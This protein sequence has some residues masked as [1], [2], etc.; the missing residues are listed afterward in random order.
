MGNYQKAIES[1]A[2]H[3]FLLVLVCASHGQTQMTSRPPASEMPSRPPISEMPSRPPISEMPSRPPISEMPSRPP[4]SAMPGKFPNSGPPGTTA[5]RCTQRE[6]TSLA[7]LMDEY[8]TNWNFS[9]YLNPILNILS[10]R[11]PCVTRRY[12]SVILDY[13]DANET[14]TTDKLLFLQSVNR[15]WDNT[16]YEHAIQ[17]N[18]SLLYGLKRALKISPEESVIMVVTTGSMV[19]YNNSQLLSE[20]YTLLRNKRSQVYFLWV[21][22]YC[23]LS[24]NQQDIARNISDL[25][26]GD[27]IK[28][29]DS[30]NTGQLMRTLELLLAKPLNSSMRILDMNV[31]ITESYMQKFNVSASLTYLLVIRDERFTLNLTDPRGSTILFEKNPLYDDN[32][33]PYNNDQENPNMYNYENSPNDDHKPPNN[34]DQEKKPNNYNQEKKTN[35]Y[36]QEKKPNNYNQ[37]KYPNNYNQEK[38]PDNN[39]Q[40]SPYNNDQETPHRN[41]HSYESDHN[42]FFEIPFNNYDSDSIRSHLVKSPVAGTWVLNILGDGPLTVKILGF[43]GKLDSTTFQLL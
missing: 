20:V 23:T 5:K 15:S 7:V 4:I 35:N 18:Q 22:G 2:H 36:N 21:P 8:F 34:Y 31:K 10:A 42:D 41:P 9:Y 38:H 43:T 14:A 12:A 39:N 17:C 29:E 11:F 37:E 26:F 6:G 16:Y 30:Q 19:D 28:L 1:T 25:S 40:E 32:R 13:T 33:S 3:L 24:P 27:I